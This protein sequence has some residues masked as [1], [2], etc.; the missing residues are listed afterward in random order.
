MIFFVYHQ[1]YDLVFSDDHRALI[2]GSQLPADQVPFHQE[3]PIEIR[4][5]LKF[6]DQ[7][8][9]QRSG[10]VEPISNKS[11]YLPAAPPV[12]FPEKVIPLEVTGQA[13]PAG[14]DN[15]RFRT[16]PPQPGSNVF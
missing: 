3:L 10:P 1:A 5:S 4:K 16:I 12:R 9:R 15:V 14:K 7:C 13:N 11:E 8:V 2:V 6:H